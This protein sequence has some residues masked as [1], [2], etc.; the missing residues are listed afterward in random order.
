MKN[1]QLILFIVFFSSCDST[2]ENK[3]DII[4]PINVLE[5]PVNA[6]KSIQFL[7][8][9]IES[10]S[11]SNLYF[12]RAKEYLSVRDYLKAQKDVLKASNGGVSDPDYVFL[13]AEIHYNLEMYDRALEELKLISETN[14]DI[15]AINA[16]FVQIYLAKKDLRKAK[17]HYQ[18]L[19][20]LR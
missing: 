16:L 4:P 7:S 1:I 8:S 13:S 14:H 12:L 3:G 10:E 17:Y 20:S 15:V 19:K 6:K 5:Q 11:S 9:L 18:K 2:S